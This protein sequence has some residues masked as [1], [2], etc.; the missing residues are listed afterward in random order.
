MFSWYSQIEEGSWSSG[1][2]SAGNVVICGVD[3]TS[4]SHSDI[5]KNN[6][7]LFGE[8]LTDGINDSICE[9]K[10]NYY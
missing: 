3:N 6:F 8:R 5:R 1:N 2:D 7:L 9:Q 4:S 10:K